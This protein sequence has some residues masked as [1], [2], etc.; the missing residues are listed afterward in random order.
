MKFPNKRELQ[1]ITFNHSSDTDFEDFMNLYKKIYFRTISF[2][3]IDP[4][5]ASGNLLGF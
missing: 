2:L 1:H 3:V 5:L 4:T